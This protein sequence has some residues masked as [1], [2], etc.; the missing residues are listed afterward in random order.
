MNLMR[1]NGNN[2]LDPAKDFERLHN[3][4]D[5]LFNFSYPDAGGLF[6]RHISPSVDIIETAD[7]LKVQMDVPGVDKKDLDISIAGNVLTVK[8]EKQSTKTNDK[9]KRYR[10]DSWSGSFQRTLSLPGTVNPEKVSAAMKDGVLVITVAKRE[11]SKPK[12]I[13]V[14]VG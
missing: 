7:D 13:S 10:S 9:A 8:G 2:E 12:Q 1:W 4:I 14:K 6:D 5:K 3:E 11:E